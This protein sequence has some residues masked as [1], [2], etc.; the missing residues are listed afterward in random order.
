[1]EE[2]GIPREGYEIYRNGNPE[3]VVTSGTKSILSDMGIGLGYISSGV[4]GDEIHILMRGELKKARIVA[5]PFYDPLKFG[6]FR[7]V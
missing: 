2:R 7:K 4:P 6:A 1:M 3:G 5:P